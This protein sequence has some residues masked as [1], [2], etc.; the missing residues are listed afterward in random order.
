MDLAFGHGNRPERS[1][2]LLTN[3]IRRSGRGHEGADLVYVTPMGLR[4]DPE[5]HLPADQLSSHDFTDVHGN[6]VEPEAIGQRA[7]PFRIET[8][9]NECAE[10]HVAGNAAEW[11]EDGDSHQNLYDAPLP[12][13]NTS[14]SASAG[15]R[16]CDTSKSRTPSAAPPSGAVSMPEKR[17]R[18]R[19]CAN[20]GKDRKSVV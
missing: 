3:E 20:A 16:P 18:S 15:I 6:A 9:G 8:D 12:V 5:I 13:L 1:V 4:R 17:R 14:T 10:G 2:G 7:Q 11:V 19:P